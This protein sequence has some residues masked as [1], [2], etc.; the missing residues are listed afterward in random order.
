MIA[1]YSKVP[2]A[3]RRP[4]VRAMGVRWLQKG[5]LK[6]VRLHLEQAVAVGLVAA[7]YDLAAMMT[8]LSDGISSELLHAHGKAVGDSMPPKPQHV[9]GP[10]RLPS[11]P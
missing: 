5:D 7:R 10:G 6:M 8:G 2:S 3:A 4:S 9:W 11:P 1:W